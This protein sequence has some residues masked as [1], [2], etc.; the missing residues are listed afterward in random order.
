M[1][2]PSKI[3][4]KKCQILLEGRAAGLTKDRCADLAGIH[5]NTLS[6]WLDKGE[7]AKSGIAHQFYLDWQEADVRFEMMELKRIMDSKDWRAHQ[8]ILAKTY[9]D[10]YNIS[11]KVESKVEAEV[12]ATVRLSD[13]FDDDVLNDIID[14]DDESDI[15]DLYD[16]E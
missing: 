8:Y 14:E 11:Q 1:A 12:K 15:E 16:I 5:R 9:P 2:R 13:L 6:N 7:K 4:K 10:E 3:S